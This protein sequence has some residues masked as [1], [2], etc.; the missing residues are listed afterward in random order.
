MA[1]SDAQVLTCSMISISTLARGQITYAD[2]NNAMETNTSREGSLESR[3]ASPRRSVHFLWSQ[4]LIRVRL[5][6][7][8]EENLNLNMQGSFRTSCFIGLSDSRYSQSFVR[9]CTVY[10]WV[11]TTSCREIVTCNEYMCFFLCMLMFSLPLSLLTPFLSAWSVL[12]WRLFL[13][14]ERRNAGSDV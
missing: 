9:T 14:P 5:Q 6:P 12:F 11:N 4:A 10:E 8:S 3:S 13:P 1:F 2:L 7:V